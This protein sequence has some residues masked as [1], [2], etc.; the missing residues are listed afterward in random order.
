MMMSL[1]DTLMDIIFLEKLVLQIIK[2]AKKINK[3]QFFIFIISQ[4][5]N[6]AAYQKTSLLNTQITT[7]IILA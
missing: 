4:N 2:T 5:R 3:W 7:K 6:H 1:N